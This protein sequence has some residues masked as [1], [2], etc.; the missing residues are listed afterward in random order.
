MATVAE[1]MVKIGA[2]VSDFERRMAGVTS[3][4]QSVGSKLTS[5]GTMLT[6]GVTLPLAGIA[7]AATK[8][9]TEFNAAMAN[10]A[11]LIP[12]NTARV[13][14]MKSA[15]QAMAISTG[16]A[17]G[18][19]AAGMYQV[20][21]AFGD[22]AD[23][24][25]ILEINAKAA[26]A[27]LATTTDAINLTS[28]VTKGYGDTSA[29]AVQKV[30][31]MAFQTVKLG[32]TDFPQLAGSIGKVVPLAAAMG[33][34][35]EDVFGVLATGTGVTG[36]A[37]EVA[38]QLRGVLQSLSAPTGDMAKLFKGMGFASGEA[39]VQQMGLQKTIETVV[40]A[41]QKSGEP[42]Q[43]FIS[44]IEGQTIA[45]ALAGPQADT[46]TAKLREMGNVAGMTD[47]AFA[48]Q[49]QGINK[50]GFQW[51]Q[52]KQKAVVA[53][54]Q[55]GDALAPS[56]GRLLEL[57][58]PAIDGLVKMAEAFAKMDPSIQSVII[59]VAAAAAAIGPLLVVIG[60]LLTSTS[61]ITTAMGAAG[62]TFGALAAPV[63]IAVTAIVGLGVAI[64]HLW[65]TNEEFRGVVMGAWK[66]IQKVVVDA[67][68]QISAAMEI[69]KPIIEDLRTMFGP[70][71]VAIFNGTWKT[72]ANVI[73]TAW[74]AIKVVIG[75]GVSAIQGLISAGLSALSGNW[76]G[77]F[78]GLAQFASAPLRL[79][80]G[81]VGNMVAG[82]GRQVAVM[83]GVFQGMGNSVL[84]SVGRMVS[85]IGN[86]FA[87]LPSIMIAKAQA[88][89]NAVKGHFKGMW[90]S[91]VGHSTVPDTIKGI[92]HWFGKLDAVM[93]APTKKAKGHV[94]TEFEK[95][96]KE[97][98]DSLRDLAH[99]F[100]ANDAIAQV[101][102]SSF[103]AAGEKARLLESSIKDLLSKGVAPSAPIIGQMKTQLD[104]LQQKMAEVAASRL[105]QFA[106]GVA[107]IFS[108]LTMRTLESKKAMD[109]WMSSV[110]A[111]AP[112]IQALDA[113]IAALSFDE[114][115]QMAESI[116]ASLD[117]IDALG[118]EIKAFG[119]GV[120]GVFNEFKPII[121]DGI[122]VLVDG[123]VQAG[124]V[125]D[126]TGKTIKSLANRVIDFASDVISAV[127]SS[128]DV[129][130]ML[131]K[132]VVA[133]GKFIVGTIED[134]GALLQGMSPEAARMSKAIDDA[135]RTISASFVQ[136]EARARMFGDATLGAAD[137]AKTLETQIGNLIANGADPLDPRLQSLKVQMDGYKAAADAASE[138]TKKL[139]G[140][141]SDA[142]SAVSGLGSTISDAL[143][144]ETFNFSQFESNFGEALKKAVI[145]Q[146]TS[147][148]I[149]SKAVMG[150]LQPLIANFRTFLEAGQTIA[151]QSM[152][153]MFGMVAKQITADVGPLMQSMQSILG[154]SFSGIPGLASGGT[155][156]AGG[157]TMV[158][159]SGPELLN[160]PRAASVI[161][162]DRRG[163][164]GGQT[165]V[166]NTFINPV[167]LNEQQAYDLMDKALRHS[168]RMGSIR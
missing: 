140:Y 9:A 17:T 127:T 75:V 118:A 29:A 157:L 124:A 145:G 162:L 146:I 31:D 20:V 113:E 144:A 49:T 165:V 128:A 3:T 151:A 143:G 119:S 138:S 46:F 60:T 73:Q 107:D 116:V 70:A 112:G 91:I 40:A 45:L 88:A 44:S 10:I 117:P 39:M 166:N 13:N 96:R 37:A 148:I 25:K 28:A 99:A 69:A 94:T 122:G 161:P 19:L 41:A 114:F 59:G 54:Q 80:V 160:L 130:T 167:V 68:G 22:T 101:F 7:I 155:L 30:S 126:A 52:T 16:K 102:G 14:E 139:Q 11:T 150:K 168:K 42:L 134:I 109:G 71:L 141:L 152:L 131:A 106:A 83:G 15:I 24:V 72:I 149:Q 27:G 2:D 82:V 58:N 57:A 43:K 65:D 64:K 26:K 34:K 23:S 76:R 4:M 77:V 132:G 87:K 8:A 97:V 147:T 50:L 74:G 36:G 21:S 100:K 156:T 53:L 93:V 163:S 6:A 158:G 63:A 137:K 153:P 142:G 154:A 104:G 123:L 78:A 84:A 48:E 159:E 12:G 81:L 95:M 5:A 111:A 56:I 35:M 62:I 66:E 90:D 38:T 136:I 33:V 164:G 135:N 55:I 18:D 115:D 98:S 47:E 89:V 86:W 32:Q 85:G 67:M 121:K 110:I 103:D 133:A 120:A 61:A 125:S 79:V 105:P 92:D 129:W 51:E 1:L 108:P